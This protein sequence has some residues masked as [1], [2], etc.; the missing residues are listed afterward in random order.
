MDK[1]QHKSQYPATIDIPSFVKE[2]IKHKAKQ[3]GQKKH[4]KGYA[5]HIPE[6]IDYIKELIP[7]ECVSS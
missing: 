7:R 2:G 4:H 6:R 1:D 3:P 5:R